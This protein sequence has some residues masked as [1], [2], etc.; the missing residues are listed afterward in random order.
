MFW[1]KKKKTILKCYTTDPFAYSF[2]KID[3]G[4]N[5]IPEWYNN[6]PVFNTWPNGSVQPTLRVCHG[7]K[8]LY[9]NSLVIPSWAHISMT[10]N[11]IQNGP[12]FEWRV[13]TAFT[14]ITKHPSN[15]VAGFFDETRFS[16]FKIETPWWLRC[17]EPVQFIVCDPIWNRPG[18]LDYS[19]L[20]GILDFKYQSG[21]N[22]LGVLE[23]RDV[24]EEKKEVIFSPGDPI[25]LLT[26]LTD[27]EIVL[28]HHLVTPS[29]LAKYLPD[30]RVGIDNAVNKYNLSKKF[31]NKLDQQESKCPFG[32]KKK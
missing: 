17:N 13:N 25:V 4:E 29:E 12:G 20:P 9:K 18:I 5:F 6:L 10:P 31:I 22:I 21:T 1:F 32:F 14:K 8:Q 3:W 24:K 2:A 19:I 23:H 30:L 15:Q 7:F 26:P 28:E 27:Q 11:I 16:T